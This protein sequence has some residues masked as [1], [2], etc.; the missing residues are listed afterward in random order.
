MDKWRLANLGLQLKNL[1]KIGRSWGS[2]V[3]RMRILPTLPSR[4]EAELSGRRRGVLRDNDLLG[5]AG[6]A[7][8]GCGNR[9]LR[10]GIA[11]R[12]QPLPG[13]AVPAVRPVSP[14]QYRLM[15]Q[16]ERPVA[17]W[18]GCRGGGGRGWGR[19]FSVKV[20]VVDVGFCCCG[21]RYKGEGLVLGAAGHTAL[22]R[23]PP[24]PCPRGPCLGGSG[25]PS[26]QTTR[27]RA[28]PRPTRGSYGQRAGGG[29]AHHH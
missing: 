6:L 29:H 7:R 2:T 1:N 28:F 26:G 27:R 16:P 5:A 11:R 8:V 21:G 9:I 23:R 24:K 20:G 4:P 17:F 12:P 15:R 13:E 25:C 18:A 22:A 19:E 10:G 3:G 14:V